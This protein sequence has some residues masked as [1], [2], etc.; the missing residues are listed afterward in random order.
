VGSQNLVVS[1]GEFG[2]E[3]TFGGHGAGGDPTAVAVVSDL[4]QV[5]RGRSRGIELPD[6]N[7]AVSCEFT[8]DL[9]APHYLRFVVRDRPGIIAAL[10]G[11]L[12]SCHINLDA[13]LQKPGHTKSALPFVITLE[14][15]RQTQLDDALAKIAEFDFLAE[16][17]VTMPI[18]K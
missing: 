18:L 11:V 10:G 9:E 6:H 2:G 17:P 1:T 7:A 5:A 12:A 4:L 13:V 15:C 14:A 8:T 3:T 16:A